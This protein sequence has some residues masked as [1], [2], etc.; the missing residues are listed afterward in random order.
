MPPTIPTERTVIDALRGVEDPELGD[1]IVSLGMVGEVKVNLPNVAVTVLLTTSGCPLRTQLR[2]DIA[3]RISDIPGVLS[4]QVHFEEMTVEQKSKTMAAA[5]KRA[6]DG[7]PRIDIPSTCKVLAVASGKGGV[8][9]SSVTANLAAAM[10]RR[11]LDVG[12]LDADI[13][14]FSVPRML[15]LEGQL[16]AQGTKDDWK[17]APIVKL[18]GEGSLHVVSMGFLAQEADAIMWRGLMLNRALQHFIEN[19]QWGR[20]DYLLVDMPPGTGDIQMGLARMLPRTEMLVI[21]TPALAAQKVAARAAD[22]A[23]KGHLRV[24]GVIENMSAF[25]CEHG[26]AYP[27][28][29]AG[30][31]E[32]LAAEVGVPLLASIPLEPEVAE[33]GDRGVPAALREGGAVAGVF[34]RLAERIVT[35]VVPQPEMAGCT[36]RILNDLIALANDEKKSA[37]AAQG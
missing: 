9:K 5:R 14:G 8:G 31:G 22:M 37:E 36:S 17:I 28:F 34:A 25:I 23:R 7:A 29:G 32:R 1:S 33:G 18:V 2:Q 16:E 19:V 20:L 27:L 24:A 21:T 13:W 26:T 15:G 10:A 12:V 35:E 6:Q 4:V 3:V 11:G 30:G